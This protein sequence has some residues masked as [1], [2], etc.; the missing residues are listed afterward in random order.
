MKF[1]YDTIEI[2]IQPG[3]PDLIVS[4][5]NEMAKSGWYHKDI[6]YNEA[7]GTMVII[8]EREIV[9]EEWIKKTLNMG[10]H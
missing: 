4:K 9:T 5:M 2:T 8:V 7:F 6:F 3:M 1:E 10:D